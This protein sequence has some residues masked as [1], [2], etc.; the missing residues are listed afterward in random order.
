ML[1]KCIELIPNHVLSDDVAGLLA[2]AD[3]VRCLDVLFDAGWKPSSKFKANAL[4]DIKEVL[5]DCLDEHQEGVSAAC[6]PVI[7]WLENH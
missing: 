3:N 4:K 6:A 1:E 5:L 2:F 7:S